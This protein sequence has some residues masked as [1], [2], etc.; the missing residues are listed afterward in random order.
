MET[1]VIIIGGGI[2][3]LIAARKLSE[4]K[5]RVTV[6][7]AGERF[8]G[9]V[10]TVYD[11]LFDTL[12]ETGPE[13]IHGNLP[14]TIGLL[15]E[16]DIPYYKVEGKS[17]H[18]INGKWRQDEEPA[19]GWNKVMK[20]MESLE[21]DISLADFLE[22]HFGAEKYSSLRKEVRQYAEGFDLADCNTVSTF[23]LRDEWLN[24]EDDVYRVKGGYSRLIAY[25]VNICKQNGVN[26]YSSARV[27]LIEWKTQ[28][29]KVHTVN[30]LSFTASKVIVTVS[31]KA[32]QHKNRETDLAFLPAI[33]EI[34]NAASKIG[35]GPAIKFFFQFKKAF[36]K[37][38]TPEA[39]FI[40]SNQ[41]VPTWWTQLPYESNML[42]GWLGGPGAKALRNAG[43]DILLRM[44]LE[45]LANIFSTTAD[46]LR[47]ELQAYRII[48]WSAV[49]FIGGAYSFA[50]TETTNALA[51]LN[52][53]V[54]ETIY[55]AGEAAADTHSK[56]TVEAAL[57]AGLTAADAILKVPVE[58][59]LK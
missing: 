34:Q 25:L 53:P 56:G 12:L 59:L 48:D 37:M 24:G 43:D 50:T 7:E 31:V 2:S 5:L 17:F 4:K 47:S 46:D 38:Q 45:S 18:N 33:P 20:Q 35:F 21:A 9:R 49:S 14:V 28:Q 27:D 10:H 8:G 30:G 55:F 15:K 51:I 39:G 54:D 57:I 1:D 13:F 42:T 26:F 22:Q 58:L 23:A 40:I 52:S 19:E 29:V 32:L 44:G 36:W 6:L 41:P 11:P 16:A 3:G